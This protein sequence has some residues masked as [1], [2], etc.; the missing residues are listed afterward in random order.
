MRELFDAYRAIE[1][2]LGRQLSGKP[3]RE[4]GKTGVQSNWRV[5]ANSQ[6]SPYRS[7]RRLVTIESFASSTRIVS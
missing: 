6:A 2:A 4:R 7:T 1:L 3:L 5:G